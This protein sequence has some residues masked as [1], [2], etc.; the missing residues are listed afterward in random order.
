M[1]ARRGEEGDG[2]TPLRARR[3]IAGGLTCSARRRQGPVSMVPGVSPSDFLKIQA[4]YSKGKR[5]AQMLGHHTIVDSNLTEE[6]VERV[7]AQLDADRAR[8][9]APQARVRPTARLPLTSGAPAGGRRAGGPAAA[10][11]SP[12]AVA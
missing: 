1:G 12:R 3:H 8:A 7:V 5:P 4:L 6:D 10:M 11:R 9:A 2:P